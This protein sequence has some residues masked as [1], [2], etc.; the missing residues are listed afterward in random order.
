MFATLS[1]RAMVILSFLFYY[2]SSFFPKPL[3]P[4]RIVFLTPH[5]WFQNMCCFLYRR[6]QTLFWNWWHFH[7]LLG[8][9]FIF[10]FHWDTH[11]FFSSWACLSK[12]Y[13]LNLTL[14]SNLSVLW[15]WMLVT[16]YIMPCG[17][18]ICIFTGAFWMPDSIKETYSINIIKAARFFL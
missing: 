3:C 9:T 17:Q 13:H 15:E 1:F 12:L 10:N 16:W 14:H 2:F 8:S 11:Y 7:C 18:H 5:S 4:Y 6:G